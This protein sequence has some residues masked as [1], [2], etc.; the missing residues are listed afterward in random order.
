MK[1]R[2]KKYPGK[3]PQG[4]EWHHLKRIG[5]WDLYVIPA[6]AEYKEPVYKLVAIVPT[7]HKANYWLRIKNQWENYKLEAHRP[8]TYRKVM[9]EMIAHANARIDLIANAG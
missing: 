9:A 2:I 1:K 3:P 8:I 5:K 6:N 7:A 4:D